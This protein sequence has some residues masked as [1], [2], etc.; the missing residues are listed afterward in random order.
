MRRRRRVESSSRISQSAATRSSRFGLKSTPCAAHEASDDSPAVVG[1]DGHAGRHGLADGQPEALVLAHGDEEVSGAIGGAE[2]VLAERA[3]EDHVLLD[4][5]RQLLKSLEVRRGALV[6]AGYHESEGPAIGIALDEPLGERDQ[7][8]DALVGHHASDEEEVLRLPIEQAAKDSLVA[9]SADTPGL[10]G[11]WDDRHAVEADLLQL[12]GAE[13]AE[14][15]GRIAHLAPARSGC[16]RP[17]F[18]R[19][20]HCRI[21]RLK[22]SRRRDVAVVDEDLVTPAAS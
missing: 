12:G 13:L 15:Q 11:R 21:I 5:F 2:L 18:Q 20:G 8:L 9:G 7:I 3:K 17:S 14:G 6:G 19:T 16:S 4:G 22:E 10:E 1:D